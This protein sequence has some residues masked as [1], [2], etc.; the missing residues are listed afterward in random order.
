MEINA[1]IE[2]GILDA[3][4]SP[5]QDKLLIYSKNPSILLLSS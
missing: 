1:I 5:G 3:T 4:W 2:D